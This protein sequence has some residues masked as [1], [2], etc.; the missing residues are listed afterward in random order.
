MKNN[1]SIFRKF[2][3]IEQANELKE[4]PGKNGI[5]SILADNITPVDITFS[6]KP[7]TN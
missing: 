2:S 6:G 7:S 3:T 4:L 1:Y 5:N